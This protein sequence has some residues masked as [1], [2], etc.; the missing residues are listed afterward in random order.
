MKGK[1]GAREACSPFSEDESMFSASKHTET[2]TQWERT[3]VG[4]HVGMT[5][6]HKGWLCGVI[7]I[8]S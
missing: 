5:G 2:A 6:N 3:K 8:A 4:S 1:E 7:L